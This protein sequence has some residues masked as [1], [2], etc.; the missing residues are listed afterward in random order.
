[1]K[2]ITLSSSSRYEELIRK[3]ISDMN[4]LGIVGLYPNLDLGIAKLDVDVDLLKHLQADHF[5]AVDKSEAL[6]V[7][8][9]DGYVGLMV[10]V[11][12]GYA[13]AKGKPVIFS[14]KP[15]DLSL[16]AFTSAYIS[17]G[18]LKE[19]KEFSI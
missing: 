1:M 3:A 16:Q 4:D 9:P 11:E 13:V 19:L 6:Y 18:N 2:T 10:S 17:L 5:A 15:E 14:Q 12:I 8:C 7:I